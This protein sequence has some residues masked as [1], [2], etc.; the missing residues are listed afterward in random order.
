MNI[1]DQWKQD[2]ADYG[3][4]AYLMWE[5]RYKNTDTVYPKGSMLVEYFCSTWRSC[6]K[7]LSF[8]PILE[9]RRKNSEAGRL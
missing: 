1:Q 2:V 8:N 5:C 3:D 7:T 6:D 4:D 9:Y